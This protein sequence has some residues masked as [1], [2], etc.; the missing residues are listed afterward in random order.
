MVV[1]SALLAVTVLV[2]IVVMM[3]MLVLLGFKKGGSH[4][5]GCDGLF[6][7]L[8]DLNSRELVPGRGDDLRMIVDRADEFYGLIELVLC[9]VARTAE[10]Y[11]SRVLD[12]VFI[13]FLEVLEVNAALGSVDDSNSS[14]DLSAFNA[15]DCSNDV[16]EFAYAGGLDEDPVGRELIDDFLEGRA[17]IAY[18]AAADT[19]GVHLGDLDARF[20]EETAVDSDLAEFVL[21]EDKLC[22]VVSVSNELFDERC[23]SC[24]EKS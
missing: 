2:M 12:L 15:L 16:R 11:R 17:E 23:L 18:E 4:V 10:D 24:S 22:S 3:V 21:D 9:D 7:S 14:A 13:E 5:S 1:R 20:L 8:E 6:D 19:A